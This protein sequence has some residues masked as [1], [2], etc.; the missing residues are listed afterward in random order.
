MRRRE[1]LGVL[2]VGVAGVFVRRVPRGVDDVFVERWSWAMGQ[3]V[4]VMVFAGSEQQGLDACAAAL[5]ELRRVERR[6]TLFDD[7]SDLCELNRRAGRGTMRVDEDLRVV[8]ARAGHYKR[9]TGGAFDVAVEPLMRAW[10][11]HR[12][13]RAA[14]S[15]A[16]IAEARQAVAS[17]VVE[18][19][20]DVVRLPN[21]HTQLDFG[22][23]GVGYGIER[24]LGVLRAR[25][26]GRALVDVSGDV[27]VLGAP[28]GEDGGGWL[29]EI[30]DPDRPGATVAATRLRDAALATAANT[31][32]VVR[33]GRL[34]LGHVMNPA[35]GWPAHALRQASVVT[36]DPLAAD[37]L[38]TAM[39]VSGRE[40]EGVM[41]SWSLT[42]ANRPVSP[43]PAP[44][45]ARD[46]AAGG[47]RATRR[48][49]RPD[50]SRSASH[51]S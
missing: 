26:I 38:S 46:P 11:F 41:R 43:A 44:A 36:R 3:A 19:A 21:A 48:W 33:Y 42:A 22:S 49:S 50:S 29:V 45:P 30:A 1:F 27:A 31:V 51:G 10:G 12:P 4:H 16:E 6:L 28:P 8:L 40:P 25:G 32:A 37:V 9:V 7:A 17:A 39:L 15:P 35:T 24:A 2:G 13:R 5:A 20:G 34:V 23:I 14:P 47:C 18:L